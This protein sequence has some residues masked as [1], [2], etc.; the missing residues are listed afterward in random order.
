MIYDPEAKFT[1]WEAEPLIPIAEMA[2]TYREARRKQRRK[3]R[4]EYI[5]GTFTL[6]RK[7]K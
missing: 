3:E 1:N 5:F 6:Y 4:W 2:R 7:T